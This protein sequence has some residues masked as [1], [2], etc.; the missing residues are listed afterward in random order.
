MK[1]IGKKGF[2]DK[3]ELSAITP[4]LEAMS[5]GKCM[6]CGKAPDFRGLQKH[7]LVHRS[8]GG[9]N[10][11]ANVQMWCGSCHDAEH[12]SSKSTGYRDRTG[13]Y[14]KRNML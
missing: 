5:E 8:Q 2:K 4:E 9:D 1:Q 10:S 11:L 14:E 12:N 7:H 3:K 6:Q 13:D